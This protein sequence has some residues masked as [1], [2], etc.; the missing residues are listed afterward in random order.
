VRR[1]KASRPATAATVSEP[2]GSDLGQIDSVASAKNPA[3]Q[4]CFIFNDGGRAVKLFELS[5]VHIAKVLQGVTT[6]RMKQC[7]DDQRDVEQIKQMLKDA[8]DEIDDA[9][10]AK[11]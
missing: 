2:R 1:R 5:N 8:T 4:L 3:R 7:L 6:E 10:N 9:I 11:S